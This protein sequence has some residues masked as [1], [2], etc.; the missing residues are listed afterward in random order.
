MAYQELSL[1]MKIILVCFLLI[2]AVGVLSLAIG[3]IKNYMPYMQFAGLELIEN[4]SAQ[5]EI[6]NVEEAFKF[7]KSAENNA[8]LT[9]LNLKYN[10]ECGGYEY[11]IYVNDKNIQYEI[12]QNGTYKKYKPIPFGIS[13]ISQQINLIFKEIEKAGREFITR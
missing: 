7:V 4:S 10:P 1:R 13:Y 5:L 11:G 9:L 12:C 3:A 2:F 6:K 8:T